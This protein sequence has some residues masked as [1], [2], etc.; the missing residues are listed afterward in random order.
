VPIHRHHAS[1]LIWVRFSNFH[2]R[3]FESFADAVKDSGADLSL[4]SGLPIDQTWSLY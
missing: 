4:D 2:F 3:G 1:A